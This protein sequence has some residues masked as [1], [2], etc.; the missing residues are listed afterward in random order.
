MRE[1]SAAICTLRVLVLRPGRDQFLFERAALHS[2]V[3]ELD[4]EVD[5]AQAGHGQEGGDH[6]PARERGCVDRIEILAP[7]TVHSILSATRNLALRER[8]LARCSTASG[9][10]GFGVMSRREKSGL[11]R[12]SGH[13]GRSRNSRLR[14]R[15]KFFTIRSSSEWKVMTAIRLPAS[16]R[17]VRATKTVLERAEFVVHLHP[18]GLEDLRRRMAPTVAAD[19]FL[20]RLGEGERF[21]KG[22]FLAQ[23]HDLARDPARRR[24]F[25]ELAKNA[26]QLFFRVAVDH[27]G[28]RQ[29]PARIHPHVERAVAHQ[30]E[31]A[32]GIFELARGNAEIEKRAAD[33]RNPKLVEDAGGLAKIGPPQSHA[34]AKVRQASGRKLKRVRIL[35]ESED[36][37]AGPQ[38][39]LGMAA[40]AAGA[41][42]NE[43]AGRGASNSIVSV[44][45]TGR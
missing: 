7:P 32:I 18:Q 16:R 41:V 12:G 34:A 40:A 15:K 13:S 21:A 4:G 1:V 14:S 6:D 26:R 17:F 20:D 27:F 25:A 35:I 37:R 38:N 31:T 24:L 43:R 8:G 3:M 39:R 33:L 45:R 36:I 2:L 10:I 19:D 42:E 11:G 29:F 30:A 9:S 28:G 23:L 22:R 44:T 5:V